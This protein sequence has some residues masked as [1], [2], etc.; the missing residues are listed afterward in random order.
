MTTQVMNNEQKRFR[1]IWILF[2]VLGVVFLLRLF[3]R[4]VVLHDQYAALANKQYYT[5]IEREAKRGDILIHDR[6]NTNVIEEDE[7]GLFSVAT[8]LELFNVVV[9]P[10]HVEDKNEASQRL[11]EVLGVGKVE[12]FDQINKDKWYIPPIKKRIPKDVADKVAALNLAGVYL[13]GQ[14]FRFYPENTFLSHLLGF[15]NYNG[16]GEYGVEQYYDGILKGEGGTLKGIKDN[17]GRV[18]KVEESEP[19]KDGSSVVLTI[20]RSIQYMI[21]KKL[22]EGLERYGAERGSI[23]V[24]NPKDGSI[25]AMASSPNFDPNLFNEVASE[26]QDI[27]INPVISMNWEPGSIFKPFIVSAA[28]SNKLVDPDSKPDEPFSNMVNIDGYEIHNS[29]DEP[30]GFETVTQILENSDN[31]G[32]IWVADKLGNDLMGKFLLKL[33][34]G[35]KT[36]IDISGEASGQIGDHRKW[37]DVNRATISFGQGISSTPIQIVQGYCTIA[38]KGKEV[39]LHVLDKILEKGSKEKKYDQIRESEIISEQDAA[40]VSHM[41]VSVVENGH[42]KKAAVAGYKVAGKTGTAQIPKTSGGYEEDQHIGSFAGFAPVDDPRFV[43][44]VKF[45]KPSN[46]KWAE[47]SAA[48]IFGEIADWLL[49]SYLK[50]P[51]SETQ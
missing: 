28:I 38:N 15:V 9:V 37:R 6:D 26:N 39:G 46:V 17:L 40:M 51:K 27:F 34:F 42:G 25:L 12:V 50:V 14:Y 45:D 3:Y 31:I 16:D 1:R 20:D 32:M 44:L 22:A 43:M 35:E 11:A 8:N 41:L 18:V 49:N 10:R 19:G 47:E 30:Y 29:T 24:A 21:E 23:I 5:R 36:G 13:E 33:G 7:N 48:P 2:L 4:Q